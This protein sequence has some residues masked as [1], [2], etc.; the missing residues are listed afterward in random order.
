MLM[1]TRVVVPGLTCLFAG[2]SDAYARQQVQPDT[3]S[4]DIKFTVGGRY[5]MMSESDIDDGSEFEFST[6][7][8][9]ISMQTNLSADL[10]LTL[11]LDYTIDDYDF[12]GPSGLGALDPWEDIHTQE[13][14]LIFTRQLGNDLTIF[15]GP[16]AVFSRE[17]GATF[18]KSDVYGGIIGMTYTASSTLTLGGGL[19]LID[20][21]EDASLR[22]FPVIILN[23]ELKPDLHVVSNTDSS[24]A[25]LEIVYNY[26]K[27]IDL[28]VGAGTEFKRFRLDDDGVAPDGV[29]EMTSNPI[30]TKATFHLEDNM[31]V[32]LTG[33]MRMNGEIRLEDDN[34]TKLNKEDFDSEFFIGAS[35]SVRF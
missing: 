13:I 30:W 19:G 6:A 10:Q 28:S 3:P 7:N 34:G 33:G 5:E 31:D 11:K 22:F 27:T 25:G 18:N 15:G 14:G 29:G 12:G 16:I 1:I 26:S 35:I 4:S 9:N 17:S 21:L 32:S 2:V 23:W 24:R 20:E 8:F